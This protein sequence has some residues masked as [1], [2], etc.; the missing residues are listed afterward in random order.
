MKMAFSDLP[1][2][3]DRVLLGPEKE[4]RSGARKSEANDMVNQSFISVALDDDN[5]GY[6][7]AENS[8][9]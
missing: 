1:S 4:R 3:F 5:T 9:A 8:R 7:S 6:V 2:H